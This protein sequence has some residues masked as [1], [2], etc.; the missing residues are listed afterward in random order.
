LPFK[1]NLQALYTSGNVRA[2]LLKKGLP[3]SDKKTYALEVTP[4]VGLCTLE[5][6]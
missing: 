5:S 2:Q 3:A 4:A 1:C 6:S